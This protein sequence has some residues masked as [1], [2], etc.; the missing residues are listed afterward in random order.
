MTRLRRVLAALV[1]VPALALAACSGLPMSGPVSVGNAPGDVVED[2]TGGSYDAESPRPGDSPQEIVDG[3]LRASIS[4]EQSW[5]TAR[6]YLSDDL[7]DTWNPVASVTIDTT[8]DREV[9]EVSASEDAA[10]VSAEVHGEA[11]VDSDGRYR[12]IADG[13][14]SLSFELARDAEGEWRI[15]SAPDGIVLDRLFFREL[16]AA[17]DLAYFDAT[18]RHIVP[19]RRW[20]LT[21]QHAPTRIVQKLVEGAPSD[22]LAPGVETAFAD[23]VQLASGTIEVDADRVAHVELTDAAGA[24]DETLSR[25]RAQLEQSLASTDVREVALTVEGQEVDVP[26]APVASTRIDSRALVLTD[27]GF[28]Y[29]SGGEVVAV[30]GMSEVLSDFP[31]DIASVAMSADQQIAAVGL[32]DGRVMRVTADDHP[33]EIDAGGKAIAPALDPHG[34][35]WT[36]R[37]GDPRSLTAWSADLEPTPMTGGWTDVSRVTAID[38]SRDGARIAA[39]V[40]IGD[41]QWVI[42]SAIERDFDGAPLSVGAP[43]RIAQLRMPGIDLAW[44]DDSTVGIAAGGTDSAQLI[45]QPIGAPGTTATAPLNVVAVG[46]GNQDSP[47]RLLTSEGSLLVMRG[48]NPTESAKGVEVLATQLG[49]P[50]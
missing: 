29:L 38:V 50:G 21:L 24:D 34:W 9:S 30:D 3:F 49:L 7:A 16:Y 48:R 41:E 17:H 36:V 28:G 44:I 11:V 42:V 45:Q 40:A 2:V 35:I 39:I 20:F 6:E 19:D 25:M 26:A 43:T 33:S 32:A 31:E 13:T 5:A 12:L 10:S 8:D 14:T 37:P 27:D 1:L 46:A 18:W 23:D 47:V 15:V 4:P 22:W